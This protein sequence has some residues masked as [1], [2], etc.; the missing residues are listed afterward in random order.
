MSKEKHA[1]ELSEIVTYYFMTQRIKP[2]MDHYEDNLKA[3]HEILIY[4]MKAKQTTDVANVAKLNELI[5]TFAH[6]YMGEKHQH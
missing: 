6:T 5:H 4:S 3:L 1:D 2:G